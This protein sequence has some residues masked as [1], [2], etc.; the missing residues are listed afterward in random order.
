MQEYKSIKNPRSTLANILAK[1]KVRP[2]YTLIQNPRYPLGPLTRSNYDDHRQRS[3]FNKTNYH[4]TIW[5]DLQSGGSHTYFSKSL[6]EKL[7]RSR[8]PITR[9]H[10]KTSNQVQLILTHHNHQRRNF[11]GQATYPQTGWQ[12]LQLEASQTYFS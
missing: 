8:R 9:V 12:D 3:K 11:A 4:H 6:E 10:D 2:W 7:R 1:P 5:Q